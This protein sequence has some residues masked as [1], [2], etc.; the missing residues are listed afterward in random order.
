MGSGAGNPADENRVTSL[1]RPI[2]ELDNAGISD[3]VRFAITVDGSDTRSRG[4][5]RAPDHKG[6][7][8]SASL[9][10]SSI[11]KTAPGRR[12]RLRRPA[13]ASRVAPARGVRPGAAGSGLVI[14]GRPA[15]TLGGRSS[16]DSFTRRS[17]TRH[18]ADT[19]RHASGSPRVTKCP[20]DHCAA[21]SM[22][23]VWGEGRTDLR[24]P[25]RHSQGRHQLPRVW[26]EGLPR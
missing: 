9:R 12:R 11:S 6:R 22:P 25:D 2:D 24:R 10:P 13:P 19:G 1:C 3:A 5:T 21:S 7:A 26:P 17:S 8:M 23:L 14:P 4:D 20:C 16:T 18:R 15:S